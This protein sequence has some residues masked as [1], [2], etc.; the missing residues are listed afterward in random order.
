MLNMLS[1]F[2]QTQV[3]VW[4]TKDITVTLTPGTESYTVGSGNDIDE[5]R[6]LQLRYARRQSSDGTETEIDVVSRREYMNLPTKSTQ[7]PV[8]IVHYDAQLSPSRLY[9]WPTGD[10]SNN[11]LIITVHR[12]L[13]DFDTASNTPD[14]PQEWYLL[15]V[16]QLAATIAPTYKGQTPQS[17]MLQAGQLLKQ[18]KSWDTEPNK[19]RI[20]PDVRRHRRR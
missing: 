3:E 10:S 8:N 14:Y 15:L 2:L 20:S 9:V 16:Y 5:D 7:A 12:P 4:P 19:I 17:I 6:F 1:K 18:L 11:T 13:E